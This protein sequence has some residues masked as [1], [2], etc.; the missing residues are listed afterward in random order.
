MFTYNCKINVFYAVLMPTT[1]PPPFL[2][3][4]TDDHW[5]NR[6]RKVQR[7]IRGGGG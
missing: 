1:P 3:D 7:A 2:G 6:Y 4:T 5:I